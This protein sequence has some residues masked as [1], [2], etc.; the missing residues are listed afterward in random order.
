ML[1]RWSSF[2][3]AWELAGRRSTVRINLTEAAAEESQAIWLTLQKIEPT[4]HSS[5]DNATA[6][7]AS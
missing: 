5:L 6:L 7:G 2:Q 3:T 1:Y 4:S